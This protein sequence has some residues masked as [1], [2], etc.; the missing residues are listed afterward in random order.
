MQKLNSDQLTAANAI[1]QAIENN[2]YHVS[3]IFFFDNP[4]DTNKALVKNIIMGRLNQNDSIVYVFGFS[5]IAAT[6]LDRSFTTH[7]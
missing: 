2:K 3:Q 6:L 4:G 1:I 5:G 7:F